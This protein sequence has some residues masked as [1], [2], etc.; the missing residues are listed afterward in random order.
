MQET[1][2]FRR[3]WGERRIEVGRWSTDLATAA[4]LLLRLVVVGSVVADVPHFPSAT[5]IRF[6]EIAH[7]SGVPYRDVAVEYP[8]GE[9]VLIQAVGSWSVGVARGL[10]A[11][12]AFGA[13]HAAFAC[14]AAGWGRRAARRYLL[15]GAPLLVFIYRR[16][17]LVAVALAV[18]GVLASR[19]GRGTRGGVLLGL[20]VLSKLWPA[21]LLPLLALLGRGRALLASLVTVATGVVGWLVLGG[22]DGVRQ[23]VGLRGAVG[24]ELESTVGAVVWPLTGEHRFEQGANRTG[25]MPGWARA[26]LA[27]ALLAGLAVVWWRAAHTSFDPAGAPALVAVATLLVLS[28]VLSPQYVAWLLPWAAIASLDARRIGLLAV[29]PLAITGAILALWYLDV[30][31]GRP[32]NQTLMIIRNLTLLLIPAVWLIGGSRVR[33]SSRAPGMS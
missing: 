27:A 14:V 31:I 20:G 2:E 12:V 1:A 6:H 28:P 23:V 30:H 7:A 16:S 17:D 29:P 13:D 32:A 24:W 11:L 22:A 5:A 15:L 21:V 8:V 3:R 9:L 25:T 10:L 26:V 33:G 18:G 19:R 4:M